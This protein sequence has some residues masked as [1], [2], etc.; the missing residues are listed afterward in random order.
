LLFVNIPILAWTGTR[1][2]ALL[3][4]IAVILETFLKLGVGNSSI[5]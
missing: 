4:N 3:L 2:I 1:S 5:Q